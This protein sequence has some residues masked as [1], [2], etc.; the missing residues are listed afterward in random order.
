MTEP[1]KCK[2]GSERLKLE[3]G[4]GIT[5]GEWS[6]QIVCIECGRRG[7]RKPLPQDAHDSWNADRLA[8]EK[9]RE[10]LREQLQANAAAMRYISEMGLVDSFLAEMRAAGIK[11]GFGV[12]GK[13]ALRLL[14]GR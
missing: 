7:P 1:M 2:C 6:A 5:S 11:D 14:E 13:E 12:R 9:A 4:V 8:E 10:A 3:G